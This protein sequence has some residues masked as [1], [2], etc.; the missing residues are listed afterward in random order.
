MSDIEDEE[1]RDPDADLPRYKV[2]YTDM[3]TDQVKICVRSICLVYSRSTITPCR[4]E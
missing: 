2:R 4:R 3:T 1:V